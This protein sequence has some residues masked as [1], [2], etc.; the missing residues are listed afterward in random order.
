MALPMKLE[1]RMRRMS[2]VFSESECGE[3][4]VL[5]VPAVLLLMGV[6]LVVDVAWLVTSVL[7]D[8]QYG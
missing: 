5:A 2:L 1:A 3:C 6:T 7:R 8:T 4:G